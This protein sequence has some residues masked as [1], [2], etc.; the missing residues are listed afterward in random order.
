MGVRVND[1]VRSV[2]ILADLIENVRHQKLRPVL[3]DV[4]ERSFGQQPDDPHPSLNSDFIS[5]VIAETGDHR[6]PQIPQ[7]RNH[8]RRHEISREDH[9]FARIFVEHVDDAADVVQMIVRI[10]K[11]S[12]SHCIPA[13]L[14]RKYETDDKCEKWKVKALKVD[15]EVERKTNSW[16]AGNET[17]FSLELFN[18]IERSFSTQADRSRHNRYVHSNANSPRDRLILPD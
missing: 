17:S 11:N 8:Q 4:S 14:F 18:S 13:G 12:Y 16:V 10:G 5:V 7:R 2:D 6:T 9:Q 1:H 3:R 15:A